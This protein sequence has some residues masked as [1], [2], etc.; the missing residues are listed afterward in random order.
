MLLQAWF[1]AATFKSLDEW[2]DE[3]KALAPPQQSSVDSLSGFYYAD[4][5][6]L[7]GLPVINE[8]L[9]LFVN[10][11]WVGV[12]FGAGSSTAG[13]VGRFS[14]PTMPFEEGTFSYNG[15][16]TIDGQ[17]CLRVDFANRFYEG[18]F[19]SSGDILDI[20]TFTD[21]SF[22]DTGGISDVHVLSVNWQLI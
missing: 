16:S 4:T 13:L 15:V 22:A 1:A 14:P 11:S 17:P 3:W 18:R 21:G 7:S 10:L 6:Y 8:F 2:K 5:R 9:R 20:V 12:E 19:L